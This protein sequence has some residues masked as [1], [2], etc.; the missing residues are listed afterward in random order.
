MLVISTR[1]RGAR[2]LGVAWLGI[3][4]QPGEMGKPFERDLK[5]TQIWS[6]FRDSPRLIFLKGWLVGW[7]IYGKCFCWIWNNRKKCFKQKSSQTGNMER[8]LCFWI[9]ELWRNDLLSNLS[10]N[11]LLHNHLFLE[12]TP[13][14]VMDVQWYRHRASTPESFKIL[15]KER[16]PRPISPWTACE[17]VRMHPT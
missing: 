10:Q 2:R 3:S 15:K 12:H 6:H 17:P 11:I 4:S 5:T 16:F 14:Q 9:A 7:Y 13:W 1:P 8:R